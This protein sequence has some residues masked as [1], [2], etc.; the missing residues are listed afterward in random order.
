[1]QRSAAT[2]RTDMSAYDTNVR[3][4]LLALFA[5][6][7]VVSTVELL[8]LEHTESTTQRLP[9]YALGVAAAA[10]IGAAVWPR[11]WTVRAFQ[12]VGVALIVIGALGLYLHYRSNAEFEREM[13]P[14]IHGWALASAALRGATPALAPGLMAQL[15]LLALAYTY[16]HPAFQRDESE[17]ERDR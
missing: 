4:I 2:A 6:G 13:E 8:L 9:L 14:S 1:M 12:V 17:G 15:G 16:R 3:R 11:T 5:L 7:V 10:G